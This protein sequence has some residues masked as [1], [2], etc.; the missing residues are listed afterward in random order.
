[1]NLCHILFERRGWV[2][3]TSTRRS[4]PFVPKTLRKTLFS[5]MHDLSHPGANASIRLVLDRF[6]WPQ[7]KVDIQQWA[8]ACVPCQKATVARQIRSPFGI[9]FH[10]LING[11][12]TCMWT[13]LD[14]CPFVKVNHNYWFALIDYLAGA[15]LFLCQISPHTPQKRLLLQAGYLV[16]GSQL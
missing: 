3:S 10:H 12:H 6:V 16:L 7:M 15:R 2:N 14:H 4:R 8:K 9:F 11:L 5:S 1:M 13:L